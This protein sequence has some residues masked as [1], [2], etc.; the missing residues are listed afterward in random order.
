MQPHGRHLHLQGVTA[1]SILK[2]EVRLSGLIHRMFAG[3]AEATP[4]AA[5][6]LFTGENLGNLSV[7][8]AWS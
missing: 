3:V 6:S 4:A 1:A 2:L 7:N 5:I 8:C